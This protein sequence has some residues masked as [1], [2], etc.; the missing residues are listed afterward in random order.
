M[1]L[2]LTSTAL[3]VLTAFLALLLPVVGVG[4]WH[5]S[6]RLGRASAGRNI[7]RWL[8]IVLGQLLAVGVT[9]L[10]VNN[11]FSFYTSWSDVFGADTARSTVIRSQG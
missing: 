4:L 7:A 2:A 9:F 3:V 8:S 5:R 1:S 11:T 10:V 6:V